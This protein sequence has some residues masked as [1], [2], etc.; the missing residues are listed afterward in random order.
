MAQCDWRFQHGFAFVAAQ[1]QRQLALAPRK[2]NAF[3]GDLPAVGLDLSAP[4]L[5][6]ARERSAKAKVSVEFVLGDMRNFD[7]KSSFIHFP[8]WSPLRCWSSYGQET[9]TVDD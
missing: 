5:T 8:F 7:W 3:D 9:P 6:T 4:M 2:R 1:D